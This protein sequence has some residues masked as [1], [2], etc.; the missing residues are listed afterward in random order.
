MTNEEIL[1]N[2]KGKYPDAVVDVPELIDF[3]VVVKPET[4][5]D[6][7]VFLRDECGLDYVAD[8]TA[9]DRPEWFEMVYHLYSIKD[10]TP[11]PFV[12]KVYLEDKQNPVLAS[13]TPLWLGADFQ[14]CEVY[15]LMGITF[16]GHPDLKR[17]LL[18]DGF[19][20]HPLRKDFENKTYTF[21]QLET[22]RPKHSAS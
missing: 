1:A 17:I 21:K 7:A 12:L 19:P 8:V 10:Q 2:L 11:E 14:E 16:E 13:V 6:V 4:L 22:T 9:V 5:L 15:D 18:W 3:T 20:G